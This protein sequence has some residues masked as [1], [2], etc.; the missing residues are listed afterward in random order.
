MPKAG[1]TL[2]EYE[3][4][5]WPRHDR[6][7]GA[8]TAN[9]AV[10]DG[11]TETSFSGLWARLLVSSYGRGRLTAENSAEEIQRIR[12]V[13]RRAVG[14]K[15]LPW[16]AEEKLRSGAFSPKRDACPG[17]APGPLGNGGDGDGDSWL[18][19]ARGR[20][21]SARFRFRI[22]TNS[23]PACIRLESRQR[24]LGRPG[25]GRLRS[26]TGDALGDD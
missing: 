19:Q 23:T 15:P 25:D 14:Q 26:R 13:W 4:A 17:E 1:N 20:I 7:H 21:L 18:G 11:A 24:R 6:V 10:A 16:Y 12:R 5:F 3:D 22:P 9:L 2:V 8:G